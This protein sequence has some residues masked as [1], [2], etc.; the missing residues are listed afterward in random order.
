MNLDRLLDPCRPRIFAPHFG[1]GD[2][3]MSAGAANFVSKRDGPII[4]LCHVGYE[5]TAREM[6]K[7]CPLIEV[8][9]MEVI[10][11]AEFFSLFR[12]G[13]YRLGN[14]NEK[15]Y[16]HAP[17]SGWIE[18]D[19]VFY[20]EN[21]G[22]PLDVKYTHFPYKWDLDLDVRLPISFCHDEPSHPWMMAKPMRVNTPFSMVKPVFRPLVQTSMFDYAQL[23]YS[24]AE[25][26]MM[27][28]GFA[29]MAELM[30]L[31]P[32]QPKYMHHYCRTTGHSPT[33]RQN[34]TVFP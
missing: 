14:H 2:L 24:A 3:F 30:P 4:F 12:D 32:D 11:K 6:F 17:A 1:G 16:I 13:D 20:E 10:T 7:D 15:D 31:R 21:L 33:F 19:R 22:I 29:N 23:I 25:L 18:I 9:P 27:D 34:W 26:N 8:F 28:S 5:V